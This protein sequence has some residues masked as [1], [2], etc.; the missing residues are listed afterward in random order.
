RLPDGFIGVVEDDFFFI[1]IESR[2]GLSI[3][4]G[5]FWNKSMS[6]SDAQGYFCD[7]SCEE[8]VRG[9]DIGYNCSFTEQMLD[10]SIIFNN[11]VI[12]FMI[13]T[14]MTESVTI[15]PSIVLTIRYSSTINELYIT[16]LI[17]DICK[18]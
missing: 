7:D 13:N 5:W 11:G 9:A 8:R 16:T 15:V 14:T 6:I 2:P 3:A 18:I 4:Q 1:I 12:V 10:M 17:I